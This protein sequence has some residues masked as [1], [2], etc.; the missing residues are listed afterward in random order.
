MNNGIRVLCVQPSS[1]SARFAFLGI[2]LRWTLGATPRPARLLIGPHDLEPLGSEA[3]FWRFALRH[4]CASRSIL[5]TR[6]GRWDVTASVDGDEVRA[7]G[8]KFALRHCLF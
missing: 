4:A 8:R 7:F 1:F 2:A 3:D 5:I 6:G